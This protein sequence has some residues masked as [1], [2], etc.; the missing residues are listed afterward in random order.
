[1]NHIQ[2][3][4]ALLND[5][6]IAAEKLPVLMPPSGMKL[7][8]VI[9][10]IQGIPVFVN[11]HLTRLGHSL[12]LTV[13]ELSLPADKLLANIH[14]LIAANQLKNGNIRIELGITEG[15]MNIALQVVPHHY[16]DP[17]D[18][19]TGVHLMFFRAS[20]M[21]PNAKIMHASL[22]EEIEKVLRETGSYEALL[23]NQH[24]YV[25]EGSKSNFFVID[26]TSIVTPPAHE[27]LEGI[28]RKYVI[29]L[30]KSEGI[31][32]RE[33]S[34]HITEFPRFDALFI[35]GTSPKVLPVHSVAHF[36]FD[37]THS[38]LQILMKVYDKLLVS[39]IH[40]G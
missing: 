10:I 21:N 19:H 22:R 29:D 2:P 7:Y 38:F 6:Q 3:S 35:T 4:I 37:A 32:I 28:T 15:S 33:T 16:P 30:C 27:V 12:E 18:Y 31:P 36:R 25:T 24:G 23:V 17:E 1:M 5:G 8:E 39:Q 13:P 26:G 11:D 34:L 9:R 20:R 14:T 40:K